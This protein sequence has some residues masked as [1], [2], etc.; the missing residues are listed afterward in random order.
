[1]KSQL[2]EQFDSVKLICLCICKISDFQPFLQKI[3]KN[4]LEWLLVKKC[5]KQ[6]SRSISSILHIILEEE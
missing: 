6:Q 5:P 3:L 4:N 1:M 2:N